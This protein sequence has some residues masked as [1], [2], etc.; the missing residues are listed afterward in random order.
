MRSIKVIRSKL[1]NYK[2]SLDR[3]SQ[4]LKSEEFERATMYERGVINALKWVLGE[5][6]DV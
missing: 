3:V 4:V 6:E 5:L 1:Q 2:N